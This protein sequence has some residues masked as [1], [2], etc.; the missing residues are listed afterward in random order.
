MA[1]ANSSDWK[2]EWR[3]L[4]I[5]G[6]S[7]PV[8]AALYF[9]AA[10]FFPQTLCGGTVQ[11]H[12]SAKGKDIP[13]EAAGGGK[14]DSRKAKFFEKVDYSQFRDFVVW[15]ET[16]NALTF[17]KPEKPVQIVVQK[18]A[19]FH[20]HV[21]PILVGTVVEWPN[22]DDVFHN[23]FSFS[24][25]KPFDLGLY[26]D[27]I[28]K[29]P[30]ETPGRVDIFCSIHKNMNC[31]VLVMANPWFAAAG[32]DGRYAI[33]D[34]PAGHYRINAWHERLPAQVREIDVTDNGTIS[35]DFVLTIAG[36]PRL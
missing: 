33:K 31:V 35:E 16:T 14:Y 9:F 7:L 17:P 11:G 3:K 32:E 21:L 23:V 20:P 12:V 36:L 22:N 4:P 15:L 13:G 2:N 24:E 19:M 29:V 10:G 1:L 26:K 28:K 30:F 8:F 18:D 27:V 5:I 6:S 25:P 34:V